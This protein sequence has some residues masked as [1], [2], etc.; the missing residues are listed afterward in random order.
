MFSHKAMTQNS[1][2][3]RMSGLFVLY[4]EPHRDIFEASRRLFGWRYAHMQGL[5][6]Y[7]L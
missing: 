4:A 2:D 7:R 5:P 1:P 3:I 6:L